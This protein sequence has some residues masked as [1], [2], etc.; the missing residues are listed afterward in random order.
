MN[1]DLKIRKYSTEAI[2]FEI[3]RRILCGD[4]PKKNFILVGPAGSG[5]G[6]NA[7]KIRDELCLC[8][9]S[10][11][12]LLRDAVAAGT[13]AGKKAKPIMEAGKLVPDEIVIA[14][15]NEA[16]DKQECKRGMILD[17]FPRNI[18]QAKKLD[19][20]L[21]KKQKYI[22]NVIQFHVDD[23]EL[24]ER[25]EGRR[26][27]PSSGRT[28]HVKFNPPKIAGKDD[29]TGEPLIQRKDDN[30][31]VLKQRLDSYRKETMPILDFYSRKGMAKKIDGTG[32]SIK[33]VWADVTKLL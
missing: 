31:Q 9:L 27:H 21:D 33:D 16:M 14:L 11:G 15:I 6:T 29:V 19:E 4:K 18:P 26:V 2:T 3:Q 1:N 23:Q 8:H 17:G 28:Y 24:I 12:D 10:T 13:D 5:K 22:D 20:M 25:I 30:A 32:K 7:E